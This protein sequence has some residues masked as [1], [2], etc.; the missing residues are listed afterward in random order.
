MS[1]GGIIRFVFSKRSCI[2]L[3]VEF[4][5]RIFTCSIRIRFAACDERVLRRLS[6]LRA[7]EIPEED[8]LAPRQCYGLVLSLQPV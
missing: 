8:P 3:S 4:G 1:C 7:W 2:E 6:E 5:T